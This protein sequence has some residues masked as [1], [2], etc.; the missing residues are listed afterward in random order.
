MPDATSLLLDYLVQLE[1]R[2]K[3]HVSLSN[4]ARSAL[5]LSGSPTPVTPPGNKSAML[6]KLAVDAEKSDVCRQLG[7][8]REIMVFATGSPDA[9]LMFIGE[10]PGAEEERQR[11][12]FV[13][14]AGQL[15]TRIIQAMGMKRGDVYISNICKYRPSIDDGQP[16]GSRNRPPTQSE[17][18]ACLPFI[19]GEIKIIQPRVIVALG[20]TA[21]NG[22]GIEGTVGRLRGRFHEFL[23]I[24]VMITYHPSYL[25]R[26]EQDDGGGIREKR[27]VWEDMLLVMERLGLAVSEKQRAYFSKAK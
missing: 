20:S 13:G 7:T 16:Q 11:E 15:L 12:P 9:E 3:T 19:T 18:D 8:L 25:L 21:C 5:S 10:A 26:S 14:P 6:A 23:G 1:G 27:M 4:K 2:G 24:P 17:M 22:L